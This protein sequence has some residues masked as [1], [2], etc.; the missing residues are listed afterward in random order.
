MKKK[1][2]KINK[3]NKVNCVLTKEELAINISLRYK[4]ISFVC[5]FI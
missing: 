1:S 4:H 5:N 3:F 2:T